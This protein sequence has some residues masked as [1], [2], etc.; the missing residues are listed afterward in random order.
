MDNGITHVGDNNGLIILLDK[1]H[2]FQGFG[3]EF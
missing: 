3:F 1:A 2:V